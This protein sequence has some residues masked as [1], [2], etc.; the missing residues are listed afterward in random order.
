MWIIHHLLAMHTM[1]IKRELEEL[2]KAWEKVKVI[3]SGGNPDNF[4][5]SEGGGP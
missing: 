3:P 1:A 5:G 2:I 4:I